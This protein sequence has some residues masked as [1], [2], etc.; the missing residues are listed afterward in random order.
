MVKQ[1]VQL[2]HLDGQLSDRAWKSADWQTI[3]GVNG[4][5]STRTTYAYLAS[6]TSLY[7]AVRCFEPDMQQLD[8]DTTTRD[9]L[10]DYSNSDDWVE[11]LIDPACSGFDY[12]WLIA[13]ARGSQTDLCAIADPDRS[14]DGPWQVA[15]H[16]E[17][18]AWTMEFRIPYRMFSRTQVGDQWG[19]QIVRRRINVIKK[20]ALTDQ[21][22][23]RLLSGGTYRRPGTWPTI[24]HL[25][26]SQLPMELSVSSMRIEPVQSNDAQAR[27]VTT[28]TNLSDQ[29][30]TIH[31]QFHTMRPEIAQGLVPHANGPRAT[32]KLS[33]V[34]IAS[35][36]TVTLSS[37]ID[38][39]K[40]ETLIAYA[41]LFNEQGAL[42]HV[43]RDRPLR[44]EHVID[45]PGPRYNQYIDE[46]LAMVK[47]HFRQWGEG[48]KLTAKLGDD[49]KQTVAADKPELVLPVD[50]E[51]LGL[52]KHI[53]RLQLTTPTSK[54]WTRD[55]HITKVAPAMGNDV[56]CDY[57]G[58]CLWL[59]G[60]PFV[61]IGNSPMISHGLNYAKGMIKQLK[62][63][64]F[65]A[66]H[67]WGGY[68]KK[69]KQAQL[70]ME[71][72]R[73]IFQAAADADL[74]VI[75]SLG[76]L[77]HNEKSSP[78]LK[79]DLSDQQRLDIIKQLVLELRDKP[80]FLGYDI[81]DEP[82]F[83][84]SPH[85]LK[86]IYDMIKEHDPWHPVTVNNCRGARSTMNFRLASDT[87][88]IDYYPSGKWPAGSYG[89][90]TSEL[91]EI[92]KYQPVK[93]WVQ[94]YKIFNPEEPTADE[95]KMMSYSVMAR[96]A[97]SLFYFIGRPKPVLWQAQSES[98]KE[99]IELSDAIAAP[100]RQ[101]LD[102]KPA[103]TN[104]Y[105]TLRQGEQ[106]TW[107][108]VV[109][110]SGEAVDCRIQ[111]PDRSLSIASW[112]AVFPP[113]QTST[114]ADEIPCQLPAWGRQ[115]FK[116]IPLRNK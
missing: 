26:V 43:S 79:Y 53:L 85:W 35:Q 104:V 87:L 37:M 31:G 47:L 75:I 111:I 66:M 45:G 13:N 17:E 52:G 84:V 115:V 36:Q 113:M 40:D 105:A 99:L 102:V 61:P 94:G 9:A 11:V 38:I 39:G 82:E 97:S 107:V 80:A 1:T 10:F 29:T 55:F 46:R 83:F 77:I 34:R 30:L 114:K 88:G 58:R 108:I 90:L 63:N 106:A 22:V 15:T 74:K 51:Q 48:Y 62:A 98:S 76:G 100:F 78:F 60:Q 89:P 68:L 28:V 49:W 57:W 2:P 14:W 112:K 95:I 72:V 103:N 91:V 96:G 24:S 19:I 110:E 21:G 56:R 4:D 23:S 73:A 3:D 93:M 50:I 20:H 5:S 70:D 18:T 86:R 71:Q 116:A 64:G 41:T 69:G 101:D 7:I 59:N 67:L 8:D 12:Y 32:Y 16:R 54:K 6:E 25:P 65:N 44:I 33:P 27:M 109:N 81:A 42:L 92:A